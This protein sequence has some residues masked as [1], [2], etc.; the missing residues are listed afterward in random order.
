MR[1]LILDHLVDL[2]DDGSFRLDL[3]YFDYCTGLTMTN[4][5]FDAL[6]GGKPRDPSE[7]LRTAPYGSGRLRAAGDRRDRAAADAQ[8]CARGHRKISAWPAA[9]RSTAS[10]TAKF[11]ASRI[12]PLATQL[13]ATPPARHRFSDRRSR[14][15]RLRASRS[16]ISSVTCLDRRRPGPCG[17]AQQS[18]RGSRGSPP[19]SASKRPLVMVSPVQ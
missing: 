5:R 3:D 17:V 9:W 4:G 11:C 10:P 7:L 1:G 2:K 14:C 16:T 13:S 18:F 15:A 6:F 19:N 8:P 12:L